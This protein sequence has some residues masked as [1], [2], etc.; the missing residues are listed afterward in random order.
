MP[1]ASCTSVS[2][3]A[4]SKQTFNRPGWQGEREQLVEQQEHHEAKHE[5][6]GEI[7]EEGAAAEGSGGR[8]EQDRGGGNETTTEADECDQRDQS[9]KDEEDRLGVGAL[10]RR[11]VATQRH[12]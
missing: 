4:L 1:F 12:H 6:D 2:T 10:A 11:E 7:S 9:P 3:A 5:A 8:R